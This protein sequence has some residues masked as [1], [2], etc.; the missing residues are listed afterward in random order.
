MK[1]TWEENDRK[2]YQFLTKR[3]TDE[4]IDEIDYKDYIASSEEDGEEEEEE[5]E[6]MAE[7]ERK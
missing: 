7:M 4:K 1:L 5:E 6:Q 3:L 2:R